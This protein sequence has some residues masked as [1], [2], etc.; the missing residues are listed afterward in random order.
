MAN[1]GDREDRVN[2]VAKLWSRG[3]SKSA[4]KGAVNKKFGE[5]APRTVEDYLADAKVMLLADADVTEEELKAESLACYRGLKRSKS[6]FVVAK[7]QERIDKLY[8]LEKPAKT[9][10]TKA[11]GSDLPELLTPEQAHDELKRFVDSLI[12]TAESRQDP[13]KDGEP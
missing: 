5:V 3:W 9:A 6:E 12:E 2:F 11:D 1:I 4:I 8:G 10:Q 7:A 13:P